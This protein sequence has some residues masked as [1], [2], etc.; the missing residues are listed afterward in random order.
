M[1]S[2]KPLPLDHEQTQVTET[3]DN[4]VV[5]QR[6]LERAKWEA[7]IGLLIVSGLIASPKAGGPSANEAISFLIQSAGTAASIAIAIALG[8]IGAIAAIRSLF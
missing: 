7:R 8:A 2:R 6:D 1:P 4:P 5:R 3:P